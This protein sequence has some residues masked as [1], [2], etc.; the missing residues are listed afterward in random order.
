MTVYIHGH[1]KTCNMVGKTSIFTPNAVI[2]PPSPEGPMPSLFIRSSIPLPA[3]LN[4][5]CHSFCLS[6]S[7]AL[8]WPKKPPFPWSSDTYA[9]DNRRTGIRPAFSTVSIIKF[10]TPSIPWEGV[11]IFRHSYFHF[12]TFRSYSY[13]ILSPSTML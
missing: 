13:F 10:L 4:T 11:S 12:Q 6:A 8:F 2:L 5:V 9:D 3:P 7:K 1:R